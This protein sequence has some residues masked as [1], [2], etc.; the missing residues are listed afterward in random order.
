MA[1]LDSAV[2]W[3]HHGVFCTCEYLREIMTKCENTAVPVKELT[4]RYVLYG[5]HE[6]FWL[7][8]KMVKVVVVL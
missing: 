4:T 2:S 8:I 5:N 6:L 3:H 7:A 1:V